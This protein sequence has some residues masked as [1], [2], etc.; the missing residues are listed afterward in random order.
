MYA[1]G[2]LRNQISKNE[3]LKAIL[4]NERGKIKKIVNNRY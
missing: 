4:K 3:I 2:I 1:C